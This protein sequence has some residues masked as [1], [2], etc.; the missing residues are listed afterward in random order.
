MEFKTRKEMIRKIDLLIN[1]RMA[2]ETECIQFKN[3]S[4]LTKKL[5]I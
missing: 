4:S 3:N 5:M 2:K 1:L